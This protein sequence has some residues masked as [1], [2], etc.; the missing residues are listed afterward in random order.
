MQRFENF[1]LKAFN[2]FGIDVSSSS[3]IHIESVEDLQIV[4]DEESAPFFVLGGGSNL[5]LS[6]KLDVTVLKNDILGKEIIETID[7]DVYV[8]V[9]GGENWHDFVLWTLEQNYGGIENLSLI[10]GTVGASPIQNIGAYGV[11]LEEIFHSLEAISLNTGEIAIFD[12]DDCA[13]G[14]RNSIFKNELKGQY[15]ISHVTFCLS[16]KNHKVNTSYGAISK[17]LDSRGITEA[18]IK[19]VSDVVVSIRQHKLPDPAVIGNSGSFFK[20]PI[21]KIAKFEKL[22]EAFPAIPSY[23]VSKK[24]VKV[25][26]GWLI[27]QAGWKGRRIGDAGC[28]EKQALVLVNH[29]NA[30]GKD[31]LNLAHQII[32]DVESKFGITLTPEVNI[33]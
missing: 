15:F 5:L 30:S 11:E 28:Y 16:K 22:K 21:I 10:P 9:G 25:P 7:N 19:E 23:P 14:Y 27:D 6:R 26:A 17:E 29:G 18:S 12:K 13:F 31:I 8:R 1:S 33:L 2:T 3:F 32:V 24:L 4:I 20:N